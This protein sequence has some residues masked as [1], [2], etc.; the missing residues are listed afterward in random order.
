MSESGDDGRAVPAAVGDAN[1]APAG[2]R[3][4][5]NAVLK[6]WYLV[7]FG[8]LSWIATIAIW[9]GTQDILWPVSASA[10]ILG[11]CFVLAGLAAVTGAVLAA[12]RAWPF[13]PKWSSGGVQTAFIA[14]GAVA[15]L[16]VTLTIVVHSFRYEPG[17]A[18]LYGVPA[19]GCLVLALHTLPGAWQRIGRLAKGSG[20]GLAALGAVAAFYFQSFYLPENTNVGLQYAL[21]IGTVV[22]PGGD[23]IVPVHLTIENQSSVIALTIGS[24]VVVSGLTW[25]ET[26]ASV[27]DASAQQN[28]INYAQDLATPPPGPLAPDTNIRSS[29]VPGSMVLSVMQPI[30]NN[31][32]LFPNDTVSRDFDVVVPD[33]AKNKIYALEFEIYVLYARTTRLTLGTSYRPVIAD[34]ASCAHDEQSSWY[35]DQSALVRFTRGAQKIFSNWCADLASPHINW[36]VYGARG[37]HDSVNVKNEIGA[38]IGVERSSRN[39]IFVLPPNAA[40]SR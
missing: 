33:I 17:K 1:R 30:D 7:V 4:A 32:Y 18:W 3:R 29:A 8:M 26:S 28:L 22:Q 24:M 9:L 13:S 14:G 20:I 15:G 34:F 16:Y 2:L 6:V 19:A 35:I 23:A 25:P 31:S 12:A 21:S 37:V 11:S 10:E 27:S 40:P 38:S 39:D 36:G 5:L